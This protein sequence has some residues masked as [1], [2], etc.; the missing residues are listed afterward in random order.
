MTE[1]TPL[2]APF[3][4]DVDVSQNW[5][6]GNVWYRQ[7]HNATLLDQASKEIQN[8]FI[9]QQKFQA[10]WLFI[11]TW[12]KVGFYSALGPGRNKVRIC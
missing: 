6:K 9:S 2:I 11:A 4:A 8:Y 3:W 7:E 5:S 1:N 10:N 12:H